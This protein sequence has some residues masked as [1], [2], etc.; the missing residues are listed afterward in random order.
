MAHPLLLLKA[1]HTFRRQ[2]FIPGGIMHFFQIITGNTIIRGLVYA[3]LLFGIL[4]C[5]SGHE[6]L[7]Y[8]NR[9][10][11]S[12][13][14]LIPGLEPEE[15]ANKLMVTVSGQGLEPPNGTPQQKKLMAERAAVIDGY[16]KL[17]ERLAGTLLNAYSA[18]GYNNISMDRITAETNAYLRGAQV[19]FV[20]F[21]DGI[22]TASVRV[23]LAPR[24]YKFYHGT[25]LSRAILGTVA[26]A[27]VGAIAG[28]AAGPILGQNSATLSA[29]GGTSGAMAVGA[30]AG[31]LGGA[32]ASSK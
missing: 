3:T 19:N 7:K 15:A 6:I 24:Q 22:A 13:P 23:Y 16:R 21:K 8:E 28:S 32:A 9:I 29:L 27:S 4:G 26:G 25:P 18:A 10:D 31:A 14:N 2:F 5:T 12:S 20:D 1:N 17:A 11:S 30:G